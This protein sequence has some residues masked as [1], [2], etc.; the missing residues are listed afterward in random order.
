MADLA[1][2]RRQL[3]AADRQH[4]QVVFITEDPA[5]DTPAVLRGWLDRFAPS[6]T[7]L[8]GGSART[9]QALDALKTSRTEIR[10]APAAATPHPHRSADS[11]DSHTTSDARSVEHSGS[12]YAFTGDRVVVYN[13]GT[14]PSQYAADFRTLLHP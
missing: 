4:L 2:A 7:G 5:T 8:I 1:A 14:T 3:N 10:P 11:D 13:G 12:V 6:F 9:A